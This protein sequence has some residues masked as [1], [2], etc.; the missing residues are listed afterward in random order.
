LAVDR[1]EVEEDAR[2]LEVDAVLRALLAALERIEPSE[3][4]GADLVLLL[5]DREAGLDD[6][7][8]SEVPEEE[9]AAG[10]QG[11]GGALDLPAHLLDELQILLVVGGF[12]L[13]IRVGDVVAEGEEEIRGRR[14]L[15]LNGEHRARRAAGHGDGRV[16][17]FCSLQKWTSSSSSSSSSSS[18][19]SSSSSSSSSSS[20]CS[21]SFCS[22]SSSSSSSSSLS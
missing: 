15:L 14:L 22:S 19:C 17:C 6:A 11:I 4:D 2:L 10:V 9:V 8:G 7:K 16:P 5:R 3:G 12:A 20:F 21:S 13:G 1:A 18:F